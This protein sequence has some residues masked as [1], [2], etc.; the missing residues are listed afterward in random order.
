MPL[1]LPG[2]KV[3]CPGLVLV[4][5]GEVLGPP[6]CFTSKELLTLL[7]YSASCPHPPAAI[8]ISNLDHGNNALSPPP[9]PSALHSKIRAIF[10]NV[11]P[12]VHLPPASSSSPNL[13]SF[14]GFPIALWVKS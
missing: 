14:S 1:A 11:N 8:T 13:E 7:F 3:Y 12:A 2:M 9:L 5:K 10:S 6:F 4:H